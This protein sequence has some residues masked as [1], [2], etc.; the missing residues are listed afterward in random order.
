MAKAICLICGLDAYSEQ[1]GAPIY[2][3]TCP[4][5][6]SYAASYPDGP[7]IQAN[8][9]SEEQPVVSEWIYEQN[10]LNGPDRPP[11]VRPNDI[12]SI[13][14]RHKLTFEER[15]NKLLLH[16]LEQASGQPGRDVDI[17]DYRVHAALQTFDDSYVGHVAHYL[18]AEGILH[19]KLPQ[20]ARGHGV[21]GPQYVNLTPRGVMQAEGLVRAH[22]ASIQGFVAM[23]FKE[24][25][26]EAWEKGF[27]RAI[28][29]AGYKPLRIDNKEH[30]N[31]I[32]DEI[33]AEIRKSRF[34]VADFTG[35][36]GGVYFEA[37]YALGRDIPVVW[38]CRRNDLENLHFDIRQYNCI[39]WDTPEE[40][41]GRLRVRIEAIIG[42]RPWK[43]EGLSQ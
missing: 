22:T 21:R 13:A 39:D 4:R 23:W 5:C 9:K 42:Q 12:P 43:R 3:M 36:R 25:M 16:V 34:V 28:E 27:T 7:V 11:L 19:V 24:E 26:A 29:A 32:C 17:H 40:L 1:W 20:P 31:K 6:G 38:T 30:A 10:R 37:G 35:H 15:V 41:A 14:A 33:V 18:E 8:I 2:R